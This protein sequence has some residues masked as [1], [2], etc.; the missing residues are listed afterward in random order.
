VQ[1]QT[2]H[3]LL[4]EELEDVPEVAALGPHDLLQVR[5]TVG[6]I[7]CTVDAVQHTASQ[8]IAWQVPVLL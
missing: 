5:S 8:H 2:V 3:R 7:L 6:C 1:A 4:L